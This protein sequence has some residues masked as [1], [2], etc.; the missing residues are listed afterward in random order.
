MNIEQLPIT[1]IDTF[2]RGDSAAIGPFRTD[3][4]YLYLNNDAI[5]YRDQFGDVFRIDKPT[6]TPTPKEPIFKQVHRF[7]VGFSWPFLAFWIAATT[8]YLIIINIF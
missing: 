1:V 8:T 2:M 7:L 3:G 4:E 6:A 5:A